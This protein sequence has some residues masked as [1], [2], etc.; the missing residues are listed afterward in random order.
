[1]K[2]AILRGTQL[3]YYTYDG[4][5]ALEEG[6]TRH[7]V[8][9]DDQPEHDPSVHELTSRPVLE[10]G[11]VRMVYDVIPRET[12]IPAGHITGGIGVQTIVERVVERSSDHQVE[13]LRA[14]LVEM[15]VARHVGELVFVMQHGTDEAAAEALAKLTPIATRR[16]QTVEEYVAAFI[17][18]RDAQAEAALKGAA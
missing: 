3:R 11:V 4:E 13:E 7:P 18:R 14:A 12:I 15:Q 6:E 1:M 9:V 16:C 5:G 2:Y 8:V 17:A 10:G